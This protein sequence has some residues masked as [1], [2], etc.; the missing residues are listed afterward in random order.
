MPPPGYGQQAPPGGGYPGQGPPGSQGG[1]N[2]QG[3]PQGGYNSG[4]G[5]Q[6]QQGPPQGQGQQF[7][8]GPPGGQG[9]Y[10]Q[11]QQHGYNQ[12]GQGGYGAPPPSTQAMTPPPQF[13]KQWYAKYFQKIP[14][15][16]LQTL[17]AWFA[18]VD[19]DR[20][21]KISAIELGKMTFPGQAGSTPMAGKPI[22]PDT[23]KKVISLFDSSG[24]KEIDFFEYAAFFEF[25]TQLQNAYMAAD[26]NR[27]NAISD[28][29]TGP[30]LHQAG[31]TVD[32]PVVAQ[33]FKTRVK[34]PARGL[35]LAGFLALALDIA[36]VRQHFERIDRDRDGKIS[37]DEAYLLVAKFQ[38]VPQ[39]HACVIC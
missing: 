24:K 14:P 23:A 38:K 2:P 17:Q 21:Q 3:P 25:C 35:D 26:R 29:E 19:T 9:G 12:Q 15:Q 5:Q 30:A 7:Q 16:G 6:F 11:Q 39:T 13:L 8:Q 4:Q 36:E 33:L 20:S 37:L 31:L 1:Y 10:N 18:S 34:A 27:S 22:G 28:Q 32:P